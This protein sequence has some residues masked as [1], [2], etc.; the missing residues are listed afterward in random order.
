MCSGCDLKNGE[1][2]KV[3]DNERTD[4]VVYLENAANVFRLHMTNGRHHTTKEIYHCP[5]CGRDLQQLKVKSEYQKTCQKYKITKLEKEYFFLKLGA[6]VFVDYID[7][8]VYD[9]N[10]EQYVPLEFA[11]KTGMDGEKIED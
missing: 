8:R 5:F 7:Y 10:M 9:E 3:I 4:F 2:T 11:L 6:T 1:R